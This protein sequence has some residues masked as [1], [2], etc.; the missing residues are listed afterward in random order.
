[1]YVFSGNEPRPF[2]VKH[3][4]DLYERHRTLVCQHLGND[5]PLLTLYCPVWKGENGIWR[6]QNPHA[7]TAVCLTN[8]HLLIRFDFHNQKPFLK[9]KSGLSVR[10]GI[11]CEDRINGRLK[12]F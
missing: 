12:A 4:C 6:H 1:M 8:R 3:P 10:Y 11:F 5:T 9:K 2:A 7:S